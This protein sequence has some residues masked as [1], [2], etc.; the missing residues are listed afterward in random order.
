[1]ITIR[2][3]ALATCLAALVSCLL[4]GSANGGIIP[5]H[6]F[7]V[8]VLAIPSAASPHDESLQLRVATAGTRH[9]QVSAA[10]NASVICACTG[11]AGS[12]QVVYAGTSSSVVARN[13]AVAWASG[14]TACRGAAVSI[15]VVVANSAHAVHAG[16]RALAL[17]AACHR[18]QTLATA[19]QFVVVGGAGRQLRR[20]ALEQ[21]GALRDRLLAQL[22]S[23][24]VMSPAQPGLSVRQAPAAGTARIAIGST[25]ARISDVLSADLGSDVT[26]NVSVSHG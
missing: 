21:L 17:N 6:R 4:V 7:E 8:A 25:S 13:V 26:A 10:A 20:S 2:R 23:S 11:Q 22:Q 19:L 9:V 5:R 16:N 14:C 24:T 1:M 18:C 12:V 3:A 15:Q